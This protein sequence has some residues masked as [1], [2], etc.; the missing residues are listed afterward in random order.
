MKVSLTVPFAAL[1]LAAGAALATSDS[2]S[3][4][5]SIRAEGRR[6]DD[7]AA[8]AG[9]FRAAAER[10]E[11]DLLKGE[12]KLAEAADSV[13][14]VARDANPEFVRAV[15]ESAPGRTEREKMMH[16][17]LTRLQA[18]DEVGLLSDP[19]DGTALRHVFTR[20]RAARAPKGVWPR[21][22]RYAERAT[23]RTAYTSRMSP[24]L[25]SL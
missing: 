15:A 20:S 24:S 22:V 13:L 1:V 21:L 6:L 3:G 8:R 5:D 11:E 4:L 23:S 19:G 2:W 10:A 16:V 12:V 18:R 17:L 9:R 25:T 14:G 7:A